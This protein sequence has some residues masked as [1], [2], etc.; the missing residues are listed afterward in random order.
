MNI[1]LDF[2]IKGYP[3]TGRKIEQDSDLSLVYRSDLIQGAFMGDAVMQLGDYDFSTR[4]GWVTLIDW[5]VSLFVSTIDLES[6]KSSDFQFSESS[7]FISFRYHDGLTFVSA[8]YVPGIAV[9]QYDKFMRAV[10]G[11][12]EERMVWISGNFPAAMRNP[13]MEDILGRLRMS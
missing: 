6:S 3:G 4:F 5:C 1:R 7:D 11:F 9:V 2:E 13:A 10:R 12:V 8:S